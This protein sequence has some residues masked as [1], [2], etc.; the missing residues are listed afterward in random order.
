MN[1]STYHININEF[2]GPFDLILFF[3]QRDELDIH[4]IPIAKITNDFLDFI[5]LMEEMDI[6]LASEF[7]LVAA[8]LVRIKSRL[9]LPRKELDEF[10][11]EIDPRQDLMRQLLE[12]KRFKEVVADFEELEEIQMQR[13]S[14]GNAAA[15]LNSLAQKALVESEMESVSLFKLME[16]FHRLQKEFELKGKRVVHKVYRYPYT[17]DGQMT[18]LKATLSQRKKVNFSELMLGM[19]NRIQAIFTFLAILEMLNQKMIRMVNG[20]KA[21]DFILEKG[22]DFEVN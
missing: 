1:A 21:N 10:G 18:M 16:T 20:S 6:D 13:F 19:E 17:S 4:D 7:I 9:L 12:Y 2:Q 8:T 11:D 14:R 3:I 22:D 15:E 5:R